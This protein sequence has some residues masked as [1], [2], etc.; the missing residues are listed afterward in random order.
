[1]GAALLEG[2]DAILTLGAF[3][4]KGST[5]ETV[6]VPD[7]THTFKNGSLQVLHLARLLTL[8][9]YVMVSM[10]LVDVRVAT[11]LLASD[12]NGSDPMDVG[13]A[14]RRLNVSTRRELAKDPESLGLLA[15]TWV[16][17]CTRAA[18]FDRDTQPR[19][20]ALA[21]AGRST[22]SSSYA[23]GSTGLR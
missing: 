10:M 21:L 6:V 14:E 4:R 1:V 8:G 16:T 5:I 12:V 15:Y 3:R 20:R 17:A 11:G 2:D 19:R 22:T 23:G 7:P 13:A 9:A 18:N